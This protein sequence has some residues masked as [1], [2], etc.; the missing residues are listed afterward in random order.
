MLNIRKATLDDVPLILEFIRE[1]AE[2]ERAPE[3]AV[4]T[5]EDLRRD[6]FS[7]D[8]RFHVEIAEW[9]DEPA[10]FALWFFNYS[11]WQGKPGLYLEDLFVRPRFR[12][13]GIG[14]ALLVHLAR[15]AVEKGCGRYQWQVL[16]WNTPAIT[17]YESLGA[18]VMKEWLTMRVSGDALDNLAEQGSS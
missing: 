16:D 10:G 8:P 9:D 1:L 3:E 2:Y 12:K 13:K 6:G 14:K 17:F 5:P 11:T 4:A 7:R 18:K 15:V